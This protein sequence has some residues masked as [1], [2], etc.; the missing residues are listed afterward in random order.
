MTF[1]I[2]NRSC[3]FYAADNWS[4]I[5]IHFFSNS[6]N[7]FK[8]VILWLWLLP[9]HC[10]TKKKQSLIENLFLFYRRL[11][12][13]IDVFV[14]QR[15][16]FSK[17]IKRGRD[18]IMRLVTGTGNPLADGDLCCVQELGATKAR[19][20]VALSADLT[21]FFPVYGVWIVFVLYHSG[22][23]VWWPYNVPW[24]LYS[25]TLSYISIKSFF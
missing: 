10:S 23:Q 21:P 17:P 5:L 11:K 8:Y 15:I 13:V 7:S 14:R 6:F 20:A 22:T 19:P 1:P 3:G 18:N 24:I 16:T 4:V 12:I 25:L 2:A 9:L